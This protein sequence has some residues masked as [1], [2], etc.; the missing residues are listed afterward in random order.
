MTTTTTI[1]ARR[2][3][4]NTI[5]GGV[6]VAFVGVIVAVAAFA[7]T[8]HEPQSQATGTR[9]AAPTHPAVTMSP[10]AA[11]HWLATDSVD[12]RGMS[13]DAAEHW[14]ATDSVDVRGMSPDASEHWLADK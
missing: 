12:I 11:E 3:P 8:N 10:D 9:L 5:V 2:R 7:L 6:S 4:H 1:P 13:P 14:L